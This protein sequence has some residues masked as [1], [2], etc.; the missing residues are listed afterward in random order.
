MTTKRKSTKLVA[1][2]AGISLIAAACGDDDADPDDPADVTGEGETPPGDDTTPMTD[3][4]TP[5]T[6]DTTPPATGDT[7]PMT[8][9]TTPMTGDT[10]PMTGD[11]TPMTG[12]TTPSTEDAA[13]AGGSFTYG[14]GQEFSDYNNNT[15]NGNSV[16]NGIVLNRVLPSPFNFSG[17]DGALLMDENLMESADLTSED[18]QVIE[19][20][21]NPDAAWSDG[22]PIDCD[23]FQLAQLSQNGLYLQLDENGEPALDDAGSEIPL[24]Q[25][26]G[27]TGNDQIE[28]VEC[29]EDGKT[30]TTTYETPYP[31]WQGLFG[32]LMPAHILEQEAGVEDVGAL[33]EATDFDQPG[34]TY[35]QLLAAGE[36]WNTGWTF[37]PGQLNEGISPSGGEFQISEWTAGQSLTLVPNE[38][39]WGPPAQLDSLTIRILADTAQA[40]ALQNGEILAMDP[41][42]N[43]DLLAQL[44]GAGGVTVETGEDFTFEHFDF[45][46]RNEDLAQFEVRQAFAKCLPREQMVEE[47]IR[48][49]NPEAEVLN[50]RWFEGFE[51]GYQDNSGGEYDD[52]DLEGA[53]ALLEEAGYTEPIQLRIGWLNDPEAPN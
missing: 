42:P 34:D 15:T 5:M 32:N 24:F 9:D 16:K 49:L 31:D 37:E 48:P 44:E 30:V 28:T 3:E 2:L 22:E 23:D 53:Q 20:V 36:F 33:L 26:A 4:M 18:P 50:S 38:E 45:N 12:D 1:V 27:T 14:Y 47:L 19:Y 11:T 10:T 52:V 7:T 8:G 46:F 17:P 41:Q 21:I 29:S 25:P 51:P 40:Q 43:A 6:G 35:D 39:Y 13:A